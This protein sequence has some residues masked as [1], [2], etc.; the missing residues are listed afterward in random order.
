MSTE[1]P[2]VVRFLRL[3]ERKPCVERDNAALHQD[4]T[5]Y[6]AQCGMRVSFVQVIDEREMRSAEKDFR[7]NQLASLRMLAEK[8]IALFA[9]ASIE[10]VD[11][12]R[13]VDRAKREITHLPFH[14]RRVRWISRPRRLRKGW[15]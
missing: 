5:L 7:C 9:F 3:L 12:L 15:G 13:S 8:R 2:V 14:N 10:A 11:S 1:N 6:E 4:A